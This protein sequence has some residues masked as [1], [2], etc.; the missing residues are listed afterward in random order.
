MQHNTAVPAQAVMVERNGS[1]CWLLGTALM[2]DTPT[3]QEAAAAEQPIK[4]SPI[5]SA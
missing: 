3:R 4:P 5:Q 2:L 1:N